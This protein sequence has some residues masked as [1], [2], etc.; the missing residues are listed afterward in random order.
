MPF[1]D[2]L[3]AFTGV[4]L[5]PM[6]AA[7]VIT[8]IAAT[9]QGTVGLGF[10][11][12]SV[13]SLAM[14]DPRLSPVPQLL[15]AFPLVIGMLW[16]ERHGV[17][18][19]GFGQIVLGR[20]PGA[21]LGYLLVEYF[22]RSSLEL[23]IAAIIGM[24]VVVAVRNSRARSGPATPP[25]GA[26]RFA[27]GWVSGTSSYVASIGGPPIALLYRNAQ[28]PTLRATMAAVF[29]VGLT[30]TLVSRTA[31]GH[32]ARGDVHVALVLA[33]SVV[34]G[35]LASRALRGR[36]E[37]PWLRTAVLVISGAAALALAARN[38]MG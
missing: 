16:S 13:P 22:D 30:L 31:A 27:A 18:R 4:E 19:S 9:I 11:L 17:D 7:I 8:A 37:G 1:F 3:V 36:V 20:L 23:A 35:L 24:A 33:P 34:V 10:G 2:T 12:I 26:L 25:S 5:V 14:L 6:L 28:G 15:I 32:I 38:L 29:L 21:G